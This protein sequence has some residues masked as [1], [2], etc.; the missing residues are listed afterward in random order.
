M[1]NARLHG[2]KELTAYL[3]KLQ[4]GTKI[5]AMTAAAE[6]ILGDERH[7]LRHAPKRVQHGENN[8]YQWQSDKQRR[9]YFAS[10][11]FGGGIPYQRTDEM[12]NAWEWSASN[13]DWT[14]VVVFNP[15]E[16]ATYVI[17]DDQ[18][19]GHKA[20]GWRYYMDVIKTNL[21]GAIQAAQRAVDA[22]VNRT[23]S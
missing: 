19:R 2:Q 6:Y 15:V 10:D 18:Q 16:T 8:P 13:S 7:G 23:K 9:A 17:G 22:F 4:R 21:K 3:K 5:H 1:I 14:R 12:V 20:D 11:G